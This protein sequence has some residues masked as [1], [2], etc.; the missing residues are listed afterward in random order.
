MGFK[1]TITFRE[2]TLVAVLMDT[3]GSLARHGIKRFVLMN[4]HGGNTQ[5]VNLTMQLAKQ[6]FRVMMASPEGP[7][8]TST[9]KARIERQR[10]HW[11]VHSGPTE[12]STALH[13]FPELVEM[14]RLEGWKPTLSMHPEL[15]KLLDPERG[16]YE[17]A[18][19]L[20]RACTEPDTH[21][22]TSSGVY[23]KN[24]PR[25]ADPEEA[26]VRFEEKV[27]F[28]VDFI[29]MWKTIPIPRAFRNRP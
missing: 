24:D 18:S 11:D 23:G 16:D 1:G 12:T 4:G 6:E 29:R 21:D 15:I 13:L 5:I 20:F 19:Q 27:M 26:R 17:L 22:F 28:V 2:T 7:T 8:R 14:G 3:V 10:R 9:A 25:E